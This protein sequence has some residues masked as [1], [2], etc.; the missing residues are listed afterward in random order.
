[1]FRVG[2]SEALMEVLTQNQAKQIVK[3][4]MA[5]LPYNINIMNNQGIIIA[6]G[7]KSRIGTLHLGALKAINEKKIV[8]VYTDT[9]TEKRGTNE[10][11]F[12]DGKVIGVIGITGEPDEVRPFTKLVSTIVQLF[13]EEQCNYINQAKT[14]QL[15]KTFIDTLTAAKDPKNYP[16]KL[17]EEALD[18]YSLD[19]TTPKIGVLADNQE[20]LS[21]LFPEREIFSYHTSWVVFTKPSNLSVNLLE[22]TD[23]DLVF[24][25]S[26][27]PHSNAV[28]EK[29]GSKVIVSDPDTNLG[30]ILIELWNTFALSKFFNLSEKVIFCADYRFYAN[31][32]HSFP[33]RDELLMEKLKSLD[34]ESRKTLIAFFKNNSHVN[35]TAEVL[36]IHRNTLHFRMRKIESITGRDPF[37]NSD[38]FEL[39]Y[40]SVLLF[41][42]EMTTESG[43]ATLT[44]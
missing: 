41:R 36:Q 34:D 9:S 13:L 39:L 12:F 44:R 22:R 16:Q 32:L 2:E 14:R 4:L 40:H 11:I 19:I 24:A 26:S 8:I 38:L 27:T 31:L 28:L 43:T 35:K 10:P 3:R 7:D 23:S 25:Q 15:K 33:Y 5:C 29:P 21:A 20:T 42:D 37:L 17:I 6:S 1:M 30:Q 18:N